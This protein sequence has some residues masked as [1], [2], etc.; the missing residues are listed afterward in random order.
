M[1]HT[2]TPGVGVLWL[3]L[4]LA[5]LFVG[6]SI[7]PYALPRAELSNS[8]SWEAGFDNG[9]AFL[10]Y[11]LILGLPS[12]FV[13]RLLRPARGEAPTVDD[14]ARVRWTPP[15]SVW[16]VIGLHAIVFGAVYAVRNRFVFGEANTFQDQI[17]RMTTGDVP[18]VD[19]FYTYGPALIYPPFFLSRSLGIDASYALF[20]VATY[21]A[22]LYAL[23]LVLQVVLKRDARLGGWFVFLSVGF[24]NPYAGLNY[25]L[26]R[27][28]LPF[29]VLGA[30]ALYFRTGSGRALGL[31]AGSLALALLYSMDIAAVAAGGVGLLFGLDLIAPRAS[32]RAAGAGPIAGGPSAGALLGRALAVSAVAAGLAVLFARMVDPSWRAARGYAG[33][34]VR[35]ASGFSNLPIY[36]SVPFV[37][38][39]ALTI[40]ALALVLHRFKETGRRGQLGL[41]MA[42]LA[43][44]LAMQR[45]AFGQ[46][47]IAHIAFYGLPIVLAC[48]ALA[49]GT[50]DG[51]RA[52]RWIATA[53]LVGVVG[54]LQL[55]HAVLFAPYVSRVLRLHNVAVA[56]PAAETPALRSAEVVQATLDRIVRE[57]GADRSYYMYNL[58]YYS[59]AIHRKYRLRHIDY[60]AVKNCVGPGDIRALIA[61][62]QAAK[63]IVI[64][65]AG[66]LAAVA[67]AP[68]PVGWAGK[69]AAGL[70][71]LTFDSPVQALHRANQARL[72]EPLRQYL[73]TSYRVALESGGL[74]VLTPRGGEAPI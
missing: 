1:A 10:A 31:A 14:V 28:L 2:R 57:F 15:A 52:R 40:V 44:A 42:G 33:V 19:F 55:H 32:S 67:S 5:L 30:A 13:A 43:V 47:E 74:V 20:Y 25:T 59:S 64:A 39:V 53:V 72:R 4:S 27:F 11:V 23:Y 66:D 38:M 22:G 73:R 12:Y 35:F 9:G 69:L 49:G 17:F 48:I 50:G 26:V 34:A 36:P 54:P 58:E 70:G 29:C 65:S 61:R 63:P 7:V 62:L 51:L 37:V 41:T 60:C 45:G 46:P 3:V 18:Y 16:A 21:L 56:T 6:I 8:A 68:R 71:I 24:F